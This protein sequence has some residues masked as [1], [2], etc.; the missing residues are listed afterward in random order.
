MSN[1][2][3]LLSVRDLRVSFEIQGGSVEAVK[4]VSFDVLPGQVVALV[5]ES[6]S[7]KSV[8]AQTIL[9]ILP[10]NANIEQGSILLRDPQQPEDEVDIA[11]LAANDPYLLKMRGGRISMVFQEPMTA[12]SPIHTVGSQVEEALIL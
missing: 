4:G 3:S 2:E 1:A 10:R 11:S 12:L 5:G 7:G 8:I 6:G 9:R